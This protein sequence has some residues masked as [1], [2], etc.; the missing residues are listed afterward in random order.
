VNAVIQTDA[1]SKL[2]GSTVALK[3]LTLRVDAGEVF[4]LIGPNGA[5]KTTTMRLLLDAIRP[6]S[7]SLWVFGQAPRVAGPALRARLAFLPGE[8]KLASRATGRELLAFYARLQ[9]SVAPS[10]YEGL[11][12]RLG[13][14]LGARVGSLSKGNKQ[15]LGLVQAFMR[16]A[17]LLILDEPTSGLDPVMQRE[18]L[19][20]VREAQAAGST[21]LLSSHVLSEVQQVAGRVGILRRGELARL[22]SV[23]AVRAAA[24]RL[25]RVSAL[26]PD[27]PHVQAALEALPG[28]TSVTVLLHGGGDTG[29]VDARY[30]GPAAPLLQLLGSL[31]VVDLVLAEPDLE[32]AVM[33]LYSGGPTEQAP[34]AATEVGS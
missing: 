34:S 14:N 30:A 8:L 18:F 9:G 3:D 12:E 31:P 27:V 6:S 24:P 5:G 28:A 22:E 19:S 11:A 2:F 26:V 17:E 33:S 10:E 4:G 21:V 29:D 25:V 15:K 1:L 13:L 32:E 20:L 23:A 16:K 7:G